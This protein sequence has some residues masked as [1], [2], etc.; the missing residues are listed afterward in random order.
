METCQE[1]LTEDLTVGERIIAGLKEVFEYKQG[2][3]KL[4][5]KIVIVNGDQSLEQGGG[6]IMDTMDNRRKPAKNTAANE[7]KLDL[8]QDAFDKMRLTEAER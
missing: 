8:L 3:R 5:S 6:P 1:I 7:G 4:R 2:K